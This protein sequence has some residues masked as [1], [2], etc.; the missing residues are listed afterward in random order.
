MTNIHWVSHNL[1]GGSRRMRMKKKKSD[2]FNEYGD[3]PPALTILG[4]TSFST[5]E[6]ALALLGG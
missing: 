1:R 4:W 3:R 2:G 6:A 5:E